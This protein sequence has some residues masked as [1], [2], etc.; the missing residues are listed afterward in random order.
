MNKCPKC[1][2]VYDAH[3]EFCWAD[4]EL[5]VPQEAST[6]AMIPALEP[7]GRPWL[8]LGMFALFGTSAVATLLALLGLVGVLLFTG[9]PEVA[10]RPP[11]EGTA[12]EAGADPLALPR[13]YIEDASELLLQGR[14]QD[15]KVLLERALA[16]EPQDPGM[17]LLLERQL[18][19]I[20]QLSVPAP[21]EEPPHEAPQPTHP[22]P[23]PA[24]PVPVGS[25]AAGGKEPPA[26]A[27][28]AEPG[29]PGAGTTD[30]GDALAEGTP[31]PIAEGTP[32]AQAGG[33]DAQAGGADAQAGGAG[34]PALVGAPD[35][36]PTSSGA[37]TGGGPATAPAPAR[38]AAG[39]SGL[40]LDETV[41]DAL[42]RVYAL[43][44]PAQ[45]QTALRAV[46]AHAIQA[47]APAQV[48]RGATAE[49][50]WFVLSSYSPGT[51]M[52][53]YP[54]GTFD[55]LLGA[56]RSGVSAGDVPDH[57]LRLHRSHQLD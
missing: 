7:S 32:D 39:A 1:Q 25:P 37:P 10:E 26:G 31:A 29:A 36:P 44:T 53:I 23:R 24:R 15:A 34:A 41:G 13:A 54:R 9:D 38:G 8:P 27:R 5:L 47:G 49:I 17:V 42:P 6:Q 30:D 52:Q 4:G 55:A 46:E 48:C 19:L 40:Q 22:A 35:V 11:E 18:D 45:L 16:L 56:V 33:A 57:L 50:Q 20:E 51:Q 3:I 28:P 21:T 2:A 14:S 12:Q 43:R